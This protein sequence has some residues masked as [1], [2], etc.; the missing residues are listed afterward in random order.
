MAPTVV[1]FRGTVQ[2]QRWQ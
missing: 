2:K 1:T